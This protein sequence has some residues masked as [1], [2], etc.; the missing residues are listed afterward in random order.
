V[1]GD[2]ADSAALAVYGQDAFASRHADVGQVEGDGVADAEPGVEGQQ[3]EQ[4]VARAGPGLDRAQ[5]PALGVPVQGPGGGMG[6][7]VT[8]D[9]G[10]A[11]AEPDMEVVQGVV[12]VTDRS[13]GVGIAQQPAPVVPDRPIAG[14][15]AG[16]GVVP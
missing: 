3:R 15:G 13:P 8:A 1:D 4:P 16:E 5:P 6:Q 7:V 9:D 11:Q 12:A 14:L 2:F 10:L